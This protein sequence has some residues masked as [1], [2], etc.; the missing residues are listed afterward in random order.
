MK[1]SV[2]VF[3]LLNG[4]RKSVMLDHVQANTNTFGQKSLGKPAVSPVELVF[5]TEKLF[6][7]MVIP[8][9]RLTK[10]IARVCPA[11]KPLE[12]AFNQLVT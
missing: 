1:V 3:L 8:A 6:V 5:R 9:K 4:K 2:W 10:V 12:H 7:K 11:Q